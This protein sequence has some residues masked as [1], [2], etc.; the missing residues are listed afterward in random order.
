MPQLPTPC[1][2]GDQI[3]GPLNFEALGATSAR[4][5]NVAALHRSPFHKPQ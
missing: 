1:S 5:V 3:L 2:A 4:F